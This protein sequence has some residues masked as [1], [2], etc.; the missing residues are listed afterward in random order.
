MSSFKSNITHEINVITPLSETEPKFEQFKPK[1]DTKI[2]KQFYLYTLE[3]TNNGK[4]KIFKYES[5]RILCNT[6]IL[7]EEY[8]TNID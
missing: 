3:Q 2:L 7:H 6:K 5:E 4:K 1:C 8:K